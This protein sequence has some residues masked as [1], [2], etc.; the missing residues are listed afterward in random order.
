MDIIDNNINEIPVFSKSSS[1]FLL[2]DTTPISIIPITNSI[3]GMNSHFFLVDL[4]IT[5]NIIDIIY[6]KNNIIPPISKSF[7]CSMFGSRDTSSK[8]KPINP[9]R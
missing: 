3:K 7:L 4:I 5:I 2:L 6:I 9:I 8:I 1:I